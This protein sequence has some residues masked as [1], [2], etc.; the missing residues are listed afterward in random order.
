[1]CETRRESHSLCPFRPCGLREAFC[2][3]AS[4]LLG[5]RTQDRV[6]TLG[7]GVDGAVRRIETAYNKQGGVERITSFDSATAGSRNVVNEVLVLY[8]GLGQAIDTEVDPK[9]WT[10]G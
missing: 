2:S 10:V 8:N 4:G 1:M 5:R 3:F 9:S 7:S 6:V